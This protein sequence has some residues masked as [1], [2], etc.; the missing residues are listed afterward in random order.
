[1]TRTI[2]LAIATAFTLGL[3]MVLPIGA[4][5]STSAY[6]GLDADVDRAFANGRL[7][8]GEA[9]DVR[10]LMVKADR[11]IATARRDGVV[12]PGESRRIDKAT[13]AA[14]AAFDRFRGNGATAATVRVAHRKP[15]PAVVLRPVFKPRA[16]V[17]VKPHKV[18]VHIR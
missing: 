16:R 1:M 10:D 18:R 17:V 6:A 11:I 15:V 4:M 14:I 13:S 7:T 2:K 8:R 3:V 12:T 5:A 9:N